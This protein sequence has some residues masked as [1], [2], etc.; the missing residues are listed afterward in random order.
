M[1]D[2][3]PIRGPGQWNAYVAAGNAAATRKARFEEVPDELKANVYIH[4][5][6]VI[7]LKNKARRNKKKRK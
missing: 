5:Q 6:T 7:A 3:Q 2:K 4:L 1:N